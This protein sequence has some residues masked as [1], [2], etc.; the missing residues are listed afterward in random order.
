MPALPGNE[1][2]PGVLV[3][4]GRGDESLNWAEYSPKEGKLQWVIID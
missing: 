2:R 1:V 3:T 4:L